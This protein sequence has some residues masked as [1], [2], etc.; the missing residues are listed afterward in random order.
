[1][2]PAKK[3]KPAAKTP[4]IEDTT[5]VQHNEYEDDRAQRLAAN[6]Q[7]LGALNLEASVIPERAKTTRKRCEPM[8]RGAFAAWIVRVST[9]GM[10]RRTPDTTATTE[11]ARR[12]GRRT[13]APQ[14]EESAVL[15]ATS[16]PAQAGPKVYT[17]DPY[18]LNGTPYTTTE[19]CAVTNKNA[20]V[21]VFV[22]TRGTQIVVDFGNS[23]YSFCKSAAERGLVTDRDEAERLH[24]MWLGNKLVGAEHGENSENDA[25]GP[26][27]GPRTTESNDLQGESDIRTGST[28]SAAAERTGATPIRTV[29]PIVF[30]AGTPVPINTREGVGLWVAAD[31]VEKTLREWVLATMRGRGLERR[32]PTGEVDRAGHDVRDAMIVTTEALVDELLVALRPCVWANGR[33]APKELLEGKF[34]RSALRSVVSQARSSRLSALR[35]TGAHAQPF[36]RPLAS[37][38]WVPCSCVVHVTSPAV[39]YPDRPAVPQRFRRT[40]ERR[41]VRRQAARHAGGGPQRARA[42]Q[43]RRCAASH[44]SVRGVHS[45]GLCRV[46]ALQRDGSRA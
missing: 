20:A 11:P 30:R 33:Y 2:A 32:V 36:A 28:A 31:N 27:A 39:V 45:L 12:S 8:R 25:D 16:G 13:T 23:T 44:R 24:A 9:A 19:R 26:D 17:F 41:R 40:H 6:A 46:G 37:T 35:R 18:L 21:G 4:A 3:R 43:R 42:A 10:C 14:L 7:V 29:L 38:C 15:T 22:C 1:M 5:T 34:F